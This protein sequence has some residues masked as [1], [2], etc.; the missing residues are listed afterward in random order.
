MFW[1]RLRGEFGPN[2]TG[3]GPSSDVSSKGD[4]CSET[5]KWTLEVYTHGVS[6]HEDRR[7]FVLPA[8]RD[9]T[10]VAAALPSRHPSSLEWKECS[11][12]QEAQATQSI[13]SFDVSLRAEE[14]R[15]C[16]NELALTAQC[17]KDPFSCA[18]ARGD[19]ISTGV[20]PRASTSGR[21]NW[22]SLRRPSQS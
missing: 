12:S 7:T 4:A 20:G 15:Q 1:M 8:W 16:R 10:K 11:R 2:S 14:A 5:R 21:S 3:V 13:L 18:S 22:G 19:T 6:S 9:K 17:L